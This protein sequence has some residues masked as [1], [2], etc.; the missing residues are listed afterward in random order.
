MCHL[1]NYHPLLENIMFISYCSLLGASCGSAHETNTVA[2]TVALLTLS[3]SV[4]I[5]N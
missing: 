1:I 4:N 5:P 2:N 3:A